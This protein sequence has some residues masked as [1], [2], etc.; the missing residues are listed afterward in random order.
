MF[1][2]KGS[3]I[4]NVFDAR[5]DPGYEDYPPETLKWTGD[6]SGDDFNSLWQLLL[7]QNVHSEYKL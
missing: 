7:V 3:R 1:V 2:C 5:L 4:N 6:F